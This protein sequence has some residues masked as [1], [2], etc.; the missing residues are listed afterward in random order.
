MRRIN[1]FVFC[2]EETGNHKEDSKIMKGNK[3]VRQP[4]KYRKIKGVVAGTSEALWHLSFGILVAGVTSSP[5]SVLLGITAI[6]VANQA[7]CHSWFV[8]G[9]RMNTC[10]CLKF[11]D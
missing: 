2:Y 4:S 8:A 10:R 3:V 11:R 5:N 1:G 7:R 9:T 6:Y